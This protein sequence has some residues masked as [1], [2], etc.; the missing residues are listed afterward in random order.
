MKNLDLLAQACA[1]AAEPSKPAVPEVTDDIIQMVA[2]RVVMLLSQPA[3]PTPE[4]DPE[5]TPEP[6]PAPDPVPDPEAGGE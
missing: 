1:P 5:P 2:E 3:Q 4:P 6:L